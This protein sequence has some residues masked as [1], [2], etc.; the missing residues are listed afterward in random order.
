M[1]SNKVLTHEEIM[2]IEPKWYIIFVT[3]GYENL[4]VSSLEKIIDK[5]ALEE[6]ILEISIPMETVI[7][8]KNGKRKEVTRKKFPC[9]VMLKMRYAND[10]WLIIMGVRG[11]SSFVGPQGRPQP[12]SDDEVVRMRLEERIV[13][14]DFAIGDK[15]S[16][17]YG[18][19]EGLI[20]TIVEVDIPAR[21]SKVEVSMFGR[22]TPVE[23]E[24][25]QMRKID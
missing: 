20:G 8:E 16:V 12:L 17:L 14:V 9:Y 19:L 11:V 1:Y 3:A 18:A 23:L 10:L 5:N 21:K 25:A 24:F 22:I 6:R 13:E 15:V 2:E 4:V 7:E